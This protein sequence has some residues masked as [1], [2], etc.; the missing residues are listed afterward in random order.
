MTRYT[1]TFTDRPGSKTRYRHALKLLGAEGVRITEAAAEPAAPRQRPDNLPTSP[2][3]V[4][5]AKLYR[6][7]LETPWS[8]KEIAL[9]RAARKTGILTEPNMQLITKYYETE[10]KKGTEGIHRRDLATFLRNVT[11]E[12][13]RAREGK[14]ANGHALEWLPA[15]VVQM[16]QTDEERERIRLQGLATAAAFR[17]GRM[18]G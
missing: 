17:E 5:V 15:K 10:R 1:V 18:Q 4:A 14:P 13:D 11:G 2:E 3:A 8:D 6:R 16:P 9:F 7:G 12:V